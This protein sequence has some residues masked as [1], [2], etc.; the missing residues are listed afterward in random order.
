MSLS[1]VVK[2]PR[3]LLFL[4]LAGMGLACPLAIHAETV[5]GTLRYADRNPTSGTT[6][7]R[8]IAF[9]RV[10]VSGFRPRFLGIW[11]W[12]VDR[13]VTTDANGFFS[14]S[15][16]FQT[17][18]VKYKIRVHAVN[19]GA[20]VWPSGTVS[21]VP[22][23]EEAGR[24]TGPAIERTVNGPGDV[25]DISFDFA[26]SFSPQHFN[27]A[28]VIRRGWDYVSARR[29]PNETDVL[30]PAGVQPGFGI[31][32]FYNPINSTLEIQSQFHFDD[33][34]LLH[35]Y[36]HF[37]E[38]K[39]SH[40]VAI[41]SIH[42]GCTT[43]DGV[44]G[45]LINSPE[46]AWME[47]FAEF[48]AQAV[49]ANNP[50]GTFVGGSGT[51]SASQLE[52]TPWNCPTLPLS[53]PPAAIENVI[54]GVLWDVFDGVGAC[55]S[56]ETHDALEGFDTQIM[57]IL[58]REMDLPRPPTFNDF[59]NAWMARSLPAVPW[60]EILRRHGLIEPRTPPVLT[61]FGDV[62]VSATGE[63]CSTRVSFQTPVLNQLRRCA[64]IESVPPSGS[65]FPIGTTQ[66]ISTARENGVV[67][68]TCS[69]NVIVQ[70]SPTLPNPNGTGL[71]GVYFDN[72]NL[73]E[74]RL[75][76]TEA[77]DFDWGLGSPGTGVGPDT[78]SVRWSGKIVPRY[79]DE[80]RLFTVSDD[81]IR[82]WIDGFL[83]I[84]AWFDH[85]PTEHYADWP[86]EAGRAHDIVIEMYENG[87]GAVAKLLWRSQCQPKEIVPASHLLPA[88]LDCPT[89]GRPTLAASF[90]PV[91]PPGMTLFGGATTDG[92]WLKLT[93]P[94]TPFGIA[95][96][97]NFSGTQ[98][99]A[100]FEAR[101]KAALFGSVCCGGGSA[102]AD[103]F[104]FNLVPAATVLPNPDYNQPGEEG[105]DQGLAVNFDTWDNGGGE[106]PAIEVKWRGQVVARQTFQ[107]SQSPWG[108]ANP[109]AATRDTLIRLDSDGRITVDYGTTRIFD[110]VQ[111]PYSPQI[112]GEPKWVI[113]A[114]IGGAND[115]HWI[116]DLKIVVNRAS[117]PSLFSTGV[118]NLGH[119]LPD[120]WGDP[121]YWNPSQFFE[122]IP[123]VAR[124]SGG[125]PIGPWLPDNDASA[126]ISVDN[127][128]IGVGGADGEYTTGFDLRGLDPATAVI[129]GWVAA[130]DELVDIR[131]NGQSLGINLASGDVFTAWHA[132]RITSGFRPGTNTLSFIVRNYDV[133][134][135]PTGLRTQLYGW[136]SGLPTG[137]LTHTFTANFA[138]LTWGSLPHKRY[139]YEAA[140]SPAGP[141]NRSLRDIASGGYQTSHS[142]LW[143]FGE[144]PPTQFFRI[145]EAP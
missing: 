68:A 22:F 122:T 126:W 78:F 29:D 8:P 79:T 6:Q 102:P 62:T 131:L 27:I 60:F 9:C 145:V 42:D 55:G 15:L 34:T 50:P 20:E 125:Y 41:P 133:V 140:S 144:R 28:D 115:N 141:W 112:I 66:V 58:D 11:D 10:E 128:T 72:Q 1:F 101:F 108:I 31:S 100:G 89:T 17:A 129:D 65:V 121:H 93:T 98:P 30:P 95:Y 76:R 32:T 118:D 39:I 113:G 99:V 49:A 139:Y 54:A 46:H 90:R 16:N 132:I 51:F 63:N 135:N 91:L 142:I 56:V 4:F 119:A 110:K 26:D 36:A 123:W 103:G 13:T 71:L 127:T 24:P 69:F 107:A 88:A 92:G 3:L 106:G 138:R 23:S 96:F 111:T 57:Q 114:R 97:N 87:G 2:C 104:S 52:N 35:E 85:A 53:V 82:V 47:G 117:I 134:A 18:G 67:V 61:C 38:H 77:V 14:T 83:V 74:P 44:T 136:G 64:A 19:Y 84:D 25:A 59:H 105:L 37:V 143:F 7:M 5:Q 33:L 130:D 80:Y 70:P 73:T 40:F 137:K 48:F 43:L 81:G 45:A 124:A 75:A 109:D 86:L 12:A 120:N 21:F 94:S 116:R